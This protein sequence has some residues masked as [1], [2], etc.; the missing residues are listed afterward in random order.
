MLTAAEVLNAKFAGTKFRPG[1]DQ[2]EVD[3]FLDRVAET[4]SAR[5]T[6]APARN[7]L[8][9]AE[10]AIVTFR[11]TKW[12]EGYDQLQVDE[13]LAKVREALA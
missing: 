7:A 13:F 1:Y 9:A 12:R 11:A 2:V 3:D 4:L 10:V 6:Q 8:T 5:E